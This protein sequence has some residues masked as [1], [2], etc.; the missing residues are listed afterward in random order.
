MK[1]FILLKIFCCLFIINFEAQERPRFV[2]CQLLTN[3]F[4]THLVDFHVVWKVVWP[5]RVNEVQ[6][7]AFRNHTSS[8][9]SRPCFLV[10][11]AKM[12]L[13]MSPGY[14]GFGTTVMNF[15]EL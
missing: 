15:I 8:A 5:W 13:S 6:R 3:D 4:A 9:Q 12:G 1:L 14:G 11:T 10:L 7:S 2:Q